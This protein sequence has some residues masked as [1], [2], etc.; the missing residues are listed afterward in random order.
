M[1]QEDTATAQIANRIN[2][3]HHIEMRDQRRVKTKPKGI[4]ERD[5][6]HH[7]MCTHLVAHS[8]THRV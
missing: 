6:N 3:S 7:Y 2:Y 5:K 4:L 8:T 1:L